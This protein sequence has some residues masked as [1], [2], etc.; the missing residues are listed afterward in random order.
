[1]MYPP[2]DGNKNILQKIFI[3]ATPFNLLFME[4][5]KKQGNHVLEEYMNNLIKKYVD[6]TNV[7]PEQIIQKIEETYQEYLDYLKDNDD[8]QLQ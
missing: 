3:A 6:E 5:Y 1:M 4:Y 8:N 7:T 2:G